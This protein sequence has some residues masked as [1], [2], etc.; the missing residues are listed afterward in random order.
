MVTF[1]L[2]NDLGGRFGVEINFD[3]PPVFILPRHRDSE[4]IRLESDNVPVLAVSTPA[5]RLE[6]CELHSLVFPAELSQTDGHLH[7]RQRV[8]EKVG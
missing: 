5:L 3:K 7:Y 8:R 2:T 6:G 4:E 1:A